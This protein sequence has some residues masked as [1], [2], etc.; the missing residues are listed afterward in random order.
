MYKTCKLLLFI[1]PGSTVA[2]SVGTGSTILESAF[3]KCCHDAISRSEDIA[4]GFSSI[5]LTSNDAL[6]RVQT[7][8][9]MDAYNDSISAQDA[10]GKAFFLAYVTFSLLAG[11]KELFA[12]IRRMK[13]KRKV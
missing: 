2:F 12:R 1:L 13:D 3:K 7:N 9:P 8:I 6:S 11:A 10:A 4:E 5:M